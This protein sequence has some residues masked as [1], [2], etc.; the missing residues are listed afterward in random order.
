MKK[1]ANLLYITQPSLTKRLQHMEAEFQVTIVNRTPKGLEFT[2][3]G[4]FLGEQAKVYLDFMNR[5][6]A[7][8]EEMKSCPDSVITIGSSYTYSKYILSDLLI[9]YKTKHPNIEISIVNEQS[10][11]LFRKMLEGSID[12]GFIRGD[13]EG[14]VN[15]L[16]LGK[17]QAYLVTKEPVD[18]EELP[19]LQGIGYKTNDRTKEIL[20]NWWK[21]RFGTEAPANMIVGYI[22][23]AWQLIHKG[24]GYTI[25]FLPDNFENEY[26]L[27]LT[28]LENKDGT[29]VYRN[30][31]F[32][33]SKNKR[34]SNSLEEFIQY[35]EKEYQSGNLT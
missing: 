5:T 30:T 1:V 14:A 27:C 29:G 2:S 21:N 7:K 16:L 9:E 34:I 24:L 4:K 33:Y 22:D 17:N 11:I 10:N 3:E 12:V 32:V 19:K 23:V 8:L 26:D 25:C 18:I 35:I 28:P 20:D 15:K 31:W 13:Y 6:K